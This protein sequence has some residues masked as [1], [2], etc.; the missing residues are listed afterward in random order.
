MPRTLLSIAVLL[1]TTGF[2]HADT[3]SYQRHVSALLSKLGCNG[4]T[5]HGAVQGQNGFRLSLFAADPVLDYERLVRE[6]RGRRISFLQPDASLIV[7]KGSGVMPH[8]GG[9]RFDLGSFDHQVLR[10]WL[11]AGAP[12]DSA[13]AA[14][15]LQLK[16]EPADKVLA[17]DAT[18]S[19]KVQAQ[20]ADGSTEDVTRYCSFNSFDS[21][22]ASVDAHGVVQ[23]QGVGDTALVVRY[24]SLPAIA[25]VL[26][27]HMGRG[28]QTP[29]KGHNFVDEHVLKKLRQ[30]NLPSAPLADDATFLRRLSLDVVG[31][32][33]EA[34]EVR[35]FLTDP[36]PAKRTKKIAELLKRPGHAALWTMKF[37]DLL[38]ASN[39]GVLTDGL[40]TEMDAPRLQGWVRAR[41]EENLPYDQFVE[42]ILLATSRESRSLDEYAQEVVDL[43]EAYGPGQKDV[44]L[45]RQRK[46]LDLYWQR[47]YANGVTG[48]MQVAHSFLGLRL[49]CAQCHRHPHDVWQQD[50]FLS[51]ANFFMR[52]R[53][54]GYTDEI[55]KLDPGKAA[56]AKKLGEEGKK[57]EQ[58]AKKLKDA[59]AKK[60]DDEVK[61]ATSD[62][63]NLKLELTKLEKQLVDLLAKKDPKAGEVQARCDLMKND[64]TKLEE[65]LREVVDRSEKFKENL[66]KMENRSKALVLADSRLLHGEALL[67]P[68]GSFATVTSPLGSQTS[69]TYRLLGESA[70]IDVKPDED[71]RAHVV[72]WM[73]RP[74]N[75][76]FAKAIVNRVWAH[77]FGRGIVD[78]PDH[79]SPLNPATHPELLK[80]LCD[81][82]IG[83]KYDLRW[84]H[85][86]ILES[87]TYQQSSQ[88]PAASLVDRGKNYAASPVRRLPAEV[89]VDALNQAT[90]VS[91]DFGMKANHWPEQL[92]TIEAPFMPKNGFVAFMLEN[93]GKPRRQ[94][95]VQCDCERDGSAS[96]FQVLTLA[97]H[98]RLWEKIAEP[99]G[100]V[101]RIV[102]EHSDEKA[103]LDELYLTVLSRFPEAKERHTCGEFLKESPTTDEGFQGVLWSLL[104][105]REFLFQ[106]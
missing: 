6:S 18:Y 89:L 46:T 32:L 54:V 94:S 104:N 7:L 65:R 98:P 3:P 42:R 75:P 100:L 63:S 30:M 14:R 77:Y 58:E 92:R 4:G 96:V 24:R 9:K 64:L 97:N 55:K 10:D 101:A 85:R 62:V 44:E 81:G 73:R 68:P 43:L 38:K 76:F 74:D 27:P 99:K 71:P 52:V 31:S 56:V 60:H 70:S 22:V 45:Y 33:P 36:D 53:P 59:E 51:F 105:T 87:R 1:L 79:L 47:R 15:V 102:K 11:S 93:F 83:A 34:D 91:E 90:G 37:G 5:C 95:A 88:A 50:D 78:P 49:E 29:V 48:A 67:S 106:H 20:F 8:R 21:Q 16:V 26:V 39:Y 28:S 69:K 41:L 66:A 17:K 13:D 61:K 40:S 80:E 82:F 103:R 86:T 72:A 19:L 84:L 57:L 2:V 25:L 35:Q 23:G 12:A